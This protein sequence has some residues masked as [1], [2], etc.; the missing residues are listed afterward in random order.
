[1]KSVLTITRNTHWIGRELREYY[2]AIL[3]EPVPDRLIAL[4][5]R[6]RTWRVVH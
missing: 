1:V 6:S 5:D 4:I 2:E 3:R